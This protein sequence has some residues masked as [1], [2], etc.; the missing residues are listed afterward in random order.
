MPSMERGPNLAPSGHMVG[1]CLSG[2]CL[3]CAFEVPIMPSMERGPNLA[4]SG[5]MVGPCLSGH[6]LSCAF[7]VPIMP[8]MER[9]PNLHPALR[10]IS[11]VRGECRI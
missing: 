1:P 5:H 4:P 9:G 3:S 7:E 6:C 8:S 10:H 2:H 11:Q